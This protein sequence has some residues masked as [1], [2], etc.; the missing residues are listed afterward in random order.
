[1]G[2]ERAL[3]QKTLC[4]E[5]KPKKSSEGCEDPDGHCAA[6]WEVEGCTTA[7]RATRQKVTGRGGLGGASQLW[8]APQDACRELAVISLRDCDDG[9]KRILKL[10][11][12][13]E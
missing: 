4:K 2:S 6:G 5:G 10:N 1:M 8:A 11:L 12:K 9:N 3:G 7:D 13:E